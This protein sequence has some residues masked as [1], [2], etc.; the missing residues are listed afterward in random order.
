MT[1]TSVQVDWL[2]SKVQ[3][4]IDIL[5][6]SFENNSDSTF[7]SNFFIENIF[8]KFH[9]VV[10]QLRKRHNDSETLDVKNE[11]DVQDLLHSLLRI[12]FDNVLPE[13]YSPSYA[14]V[15][16]RIDFILPQEKIAIETKMTRKGLDRKRLVSELNDDIAFYQTHPNC[17]LLYILVYDPEERIENPRGVE[18]ELNKKHNEMDV[19]LFIVPRF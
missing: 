9:Q 19:K 3:K 1:S 11:F 6:I 15:N 17:D 7:S 12:H 18:L 4:L 5:D 10:K 8:L 13:E 14:G 16:S 2:K